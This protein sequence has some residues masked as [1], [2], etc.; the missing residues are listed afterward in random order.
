MAK[1][2]VHTEVDGQKLKLSNLDKIIYPK[3]KIT[4]AQ[5]ISYYLEIAPII[6]KYIGERPLTLIRFPDGIDNTKFYAKSK[7]KWTPEWIKSHSIRHSEESTHYIVADSKPTVVWL[8]NLAALE[9]H[10]MQMTT[11]EMDKPDHFI[12]DLDPPE[13][14]D[15]ED[16][17]TVA[18]NL[19]TFLRQFNYQPFVKTSGSKG[20][21]IYIP[22]LK[23]YAHDEMI[24]TVKKLASNFVKQ[25]M[26]TCTLAISKEKRQGKI[27]IDILRNHESHTTVAPYSLRGKYGAPIS[28]PIHW[29]LLPD[30]TSSKHI[31]ISNYKNYLEK[32]GDMWSD[33]YASAKPLHTDKKDHSKVDE[34]VKEK[35]QSY[36]DKRD[37]DNTP[38]PG[39]ELDSNESN[40]YCIQ[41]HNAS[42]LH[43]DLRLEHEGTLLSWAIPKGLPFTEGVK[44]MAIQTE[45]HP[46]KY[47]T[48]EGIIPKGHYGAGEMW[49]FN[50]GHFEWIEKKENKYKFTLKSKHLHRSY[51]L[52]KTQNNQ[53]LIQMISKKDSKKLELPIEPML[54]KQAKTVPTAL[55]YLYEIKW[56][57][58][59]CIIH[60]QNEEVKIYSRAGRDITARFPEITNPDYFDIETGIFDGEIVCLD[61]EGKPQFSNVISRMH[62]QGKLKIE[63]QQKV[64]PAVCYLFD[65]IFYDGVFINEEPL[66]RRQAWLNCALK[67]N[68]T[69]RISEAIS[70]GP[71]LFEATKQM[72]LE[73][74][75]AKDKNAPY[76]IAQ[77]SNAWIKIKHRSV[78]ECLIAGYTK[79]EG[80]R[81]NLFGSL[82]LLND[83]GEEIKYMGKVGTGFDTK[84]MKSLLKEFQNHIIN[85]KPFKDKTD[86]DYSSVWLNPVL[87]CKIQYA[88]LSS[89]G[90]YREPVF[91]KLLN[92]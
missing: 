47:L 32:Y 3:A 4:K 80:D 7:P 41:L 92:S 43:Y 28:Y 36:F 20:I 90:T 30:M 8:A 2:Y 66:T 77:R 81:S 87:K 89:T 15:F 25:N 23:K 61:A 11:A 46:I 19:N 68:K 62:T 16:V 17:K 76:L 56:D 44:R 52:F 6:L 27:L 50:S 42:N 31:T 65:A 29:D 85:K 88:S 5:I 86:D 74:I 79:G 54:A 84:K 67:R 69:V 78:A 57:G 18:I 34:K 48:F 45:D 1:S 49:V 58:I 70:D 72:G 71:G 12:F 75:M 83:T 14:G 10:P 33:F 35:L 13:G 22:I 82:H 64:N 37:F 73:G 24:D 60:L 39:L 63:K 59:R 53:W 21:H 26:D 55:K 91:I 51:N 38:E 9:L 40:R